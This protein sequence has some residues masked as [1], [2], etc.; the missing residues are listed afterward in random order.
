MSL[1]TDFIV[2]R[3]PQ[4][5]T[6]CI[7]FGFYRSPPAIGGEVGLHKDFNSD[8]A[9]DTPPGRIDDVADGF[10]IVPTLVGDQRI[11]EPSGLDCVQA[12]L[13]AQHPVDLIQLFRAGA[14]IHLPVN[15]GTH[16]SS[17]PLPWNRP[18]GCCFL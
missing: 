17:T 7:A 18:A 9:P 8:K 10:Q 14:G 5:P 4:A 15:V 1:A 12:V 3:Q 16:K 13:L 11:A 2:A 6:S